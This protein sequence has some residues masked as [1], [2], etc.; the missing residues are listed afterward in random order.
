MERFPETKVFGVRDKSRSAV[1][2]QPMVLRM[3]RFSQEEPFSRRGL[4]EDSAISFIHH[5]VLGC[6]WRVAC[7]TVLP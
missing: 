5:V 3:I 4:F 2:P 7:T 6:T 1:E